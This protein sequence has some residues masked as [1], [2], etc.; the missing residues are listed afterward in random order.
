MKGPETMPNETLSGNAAPLSGNQMAIKRRRLRWWLSYVIAV[1]T[2]AAAFAIHLALGL[3]EPAPIVF[4][5]PIIL[6][7]YVGGLVPGLVSTIMSALMSSYFLMWP[8]EAIMVAR[9]VD[10]V[11]LLSLFVA[12]ALISILMAS[13]H[14]WRTD[15]Q[16]EPVRGKRLTTERKVQ[17]GFIVALLFLIVIGVISYRSVVGL[18]KNSASVKHSQQTI[19]Y[20]RMLLATVVDLETAHR[21][22]TITAEE[23]Y[24]EPHHDALANIDNV[25]HKLGVLLADHPDHK[26]G[27]AELDDLIEKRIAV[28][29]EIIELRRTQSF[30]AAQRAV[31]SGRGK[32]I[33]DR[34]RRTLA[35][36]E[37]AEQ[38][39]LEELEIV[40]QRDGSITRSVIVG[41]SAL[42]F[43][44]VAVGLFVIGQDFAG[45]RRAEAD[46]REA[47]DL[48]ESRVH[49]RTAELAQSNESLAAIA[50]ISDKVHRSLSFETVLSMSMSSV[51]HYSNAS[52]LAF[53]KLSEAADSLELLSS[54]GLSTQILETAQRL[55]LEGSLTGLSVAS[56]D[57]IISESMADDERAEPATADQA[58]ADGFISIIC[59]PLIFQE[60]VL[61]VMDIFLKHAHK[62]KAFERE[63]LLSIGK[64]IGLA[65]ANAQHAEILQL[66]V[67]DRK[68][69]EQSL[70]ESEQRYRSLFQNNHSVMLLIDPA[71]SDIVDAN[72]AACNF[73]G[74]TRDKITALKI[75]DINQLS[76]EEIFEEMNRAR[77]EQRNQFFFRHQLA[78]GDIREVEVHSSPI[79]FHGREL[80]YSIVHD[81]T[82]R[83]LTEGALLE[84]E[85]HMAGIVNSAMDG[86]ITIDDHQEII[87]MNAAAEKMFKCSARD[88]IGQ[89]LDGLIPP[90]HRTAHKKH[91]DKFGT[92]GVT[93][94][95]MGA[96]GAITGLRADGEEFPIEA[97]ISQV[98]IRGKRFY[99]VIL[100]DITERRR[101]EQALRE[102]EERL[103][104]VIDNLTEGLVISGIDGQL[105]HWNRAALEMHG[106]ASMDECLL[107]LPEF[108]RI[109]ELSHINGGVLSLDQW[110]LQR[111]IGGENLRDVE[112][113]I[114]HVEDDWERVFSYGGTTIRDSAGKTLAFVALNDITDRK[115]AEEALRHA[116]DDLEI[117]VKERTANL[118]EANRQ[119][120]SE[121]GERK[122]FESQLQRQTR[123]LQSILDSMGEAV[124][125]ADNDGKF[126]LYNPAAKKILGIT[127]NTETAFDFDRRF[128]LYRDDKTTRYN[129]DEL[130]LIRGIA[131]QSVDGFEAYVDNPNFPEGGW[132]IGSG[133]PLQDDIGNM[134]GGVAVFHEISE[135]KRT[136]AA[137][138]GK[139]EELREF[140]YTVS[141]D[142]KAPLRGISGYAQE[143]DRRH[144]EG[145]SERASFCVTQIITAV[146]KLDQLIEDLLQYSRLERETPTVKE[147]NL[148][149][150]VE[151][152]LRE[153]ATFISEK[154]V[155][156][157]TELQLRSVSGWERGISQI[158]SNLLDNALKY[159]RTASPPRVKIA[160]EELERSFRISVADNGIGFD[161]KYHDRIFGLFNRLVRQDEFDGTGAGLAIVKKLTEKLKGQ[162]WA[163]SAPGQ[164]STFFVELPK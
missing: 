47:H 78:N 23:S 152:L 147:V 93:N 161:M 154:G 43:I 44:F 117:I 19:S 13:L 160:G 100:R 1:V 108:T 155:E 69:A 15:L 82:E 110:P 67:T 102:S 126:I 25:R 11:R 64:T 156:I 122:R 139:N 83:K 129:Y 6:S 115:K 10:D 28:S 121:I 107:N 65:M 146:T 87:L 118:S 158:L 60:R 74:Y 90:Q 97:S 45:N 21:G 63:T 79:S 31:L 42:A 132:V 80:L 18:G 162:I 111:I 33:Q 53:Y 71:T 103:A 140:A 49:E 123:I 159:S 91:I 70:Q 105:I 5:I 59:V 153:H 58:K 134:F 12:G 9:L 98:E 113:R 36:M 138:R 62:L 99:T 109:F 66:E 39:Q 41:G 136:E 128:P 149:L 151:N 88:L 3:Q 46:L 54:K 92:T 95:T 48:L 86:I 131:G 14:R 22:F 38:A 142:L 101:A 130:P 55:P 7:A 61:G 124:I 30:A 52:G 127:N 135:L 141:H 35:E 164:G 29:Q 40:S 34:I 125:V 104:T 77:R 114:R 133:R 50:E 32:Q 37:K 143:L 150:L 2:T 106:F 16:P 76:R 163:Q 68:Q 51:M 137:L 4:L 26:V 8:R 157:T 17:S 27:L 81:I 20:M 56:R 84:S 94:R 96:L 145:L 116:F 57:V 144:H 72:P 85:A 112:V 148:Q 75:A 119:L 73:Y 24:L 89:Q 120:E